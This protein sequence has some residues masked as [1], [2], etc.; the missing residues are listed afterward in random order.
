[1]NLTS[2]TK[3]NIP[4]E[5]SEKIEF[6]NYPTNS[7]I[8]FHSE[9]SLQFSVQVMVHNQVCTSFLIGKIQFEKFK[10]QQQKTR[11]TIKLAM[12]NFRRGNFVTALRIS[13][14]FD[15][16]TFFIQ[17]DESPTPS[18]STSNDVPNC[19]F[20]VSTQPQTRVHFLRDLNTT[21]L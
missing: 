20:V 6:K 3:A 21:R 13:K 9:T 16:W 19:V 11:L 12:N 7:V 1:M 8:F 17:L 18:I 10:P 15:I 14:I 2:S 5:G 4:E